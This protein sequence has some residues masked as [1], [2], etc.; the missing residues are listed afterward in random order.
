M[1]YPPNTRCTS[2]KTLEYLSPSLQPMTTF[3]SAV[4]RL[5]GPMMVVKPR[6]SIGTATLANG[7]IWTSPMNSVT[8]TTSEPTIVRASTGVKRGNVTCQ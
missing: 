1:T 4:L 6:A 2:A 3:V 5:I 7:W 8:S